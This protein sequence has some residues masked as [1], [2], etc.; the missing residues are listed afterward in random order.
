M[1]LP[2]NWTSADQLYSVDTWLVLKAPFVRSAE[3]DEMPMEMWM[4]GRHASEAVVTVQ[5][6]RK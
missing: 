2:L 3:V 4:Q 1:T 5:V 6:R